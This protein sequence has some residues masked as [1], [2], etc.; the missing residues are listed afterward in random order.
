MENFVRIPR[1]NTLVLFLSKNE[2]MLAKRVWTAVGVD[3]PTGVWNG[4]V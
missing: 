2:R 1:F 3:D 4:V